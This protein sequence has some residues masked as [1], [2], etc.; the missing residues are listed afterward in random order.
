M[1]DTNQQLDPTFPDR[2]VLH[3]DMDA[4]YASVEVLDNPDLKGKPVIVGGRAGSRGVVSAA[5]YEARRFGVRSAMSTARAVQLCPDG[6]FL[7]GNMGRYVEVSRQIMAVFRD[8]TPLVEPLSIDEA[9][10][11]VSGCRRLFGP[12]EKIGRLIK[13]RISDEVGLTASVGLAANKF[14]AKLAS[15]LEKPDGFVVI[16]PGQAQA[17][18]ADLPIGRLWGVGKVS[19]AAFQRCGIHKVR[20]L[21]AVPRAQLISRFGDHTE[22]LLALAVGHDERAVIPTHDAKSIGNEITFA[23]DI[24]DADQLRDIVDHLCEKVGHRLR[25]SG[26]LARTVTLKARYSDFQ[27]PTRSSTLNETTDS[28]VIIRDTA[29]HLLTDKLGRRG[30]A[31]R[32]VGITA[33]NLSRPGPA[34]GDLFAD[35]VRERDKKLDRVLDNVQGRFGHKLQRG[36]RRK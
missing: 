30:R 3:V 13:Q 4:F 11:D 23:E 28:S 12:A 25:E 29:R 35:P 33:G 7:R 21:L 15:D 22:H 17:L 2:A 20:D 24:A 9:F 31:L 26:F 36:L 19:E 10:M 34:Q 27:T 14:L 16:K 8:Y 32:L 5:S 18:L 1:A 6:V